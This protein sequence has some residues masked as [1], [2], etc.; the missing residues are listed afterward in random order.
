MKK[1]R[2][3]ILIQA[4][5]GSTRLPG[6]HLK[7]VLGKPL[8]GYLLER[9][10]RVRNADAIVLATTTNPLD[11]ALV[12]FSKKNHLP[13]FRGSE[14]DVLDRFYQC[15]KTNA[16]DVIVRIT[17]DCPLIDP[18]VIDLVIE[19]YLKN[20][21]SLDYVS[22]TEKRTFPRGFD[23]EVFSFES[24]QKVASEAGKPEEREHVTPYYYR[25]PDL[26]RIGSVTRPVDESRYRWTVDTQDDFKLISTVL[27]NIYPE[28]PNFTFNDLL[29]LFQRHPDWIKINVHVQQKIL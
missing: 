13:Y 19:H 5:M 15:A 25:H 10:R 14:E 4:R 27:E 9:L 26:F 12:D 8:I 1:P 28:K 21:A 2:V 24:L 7:E 3:V 17:G 18:A 29:E 22:N 20:R 23:V 11:D 6:K 16:A